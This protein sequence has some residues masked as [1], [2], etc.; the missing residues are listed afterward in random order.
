MSTIQQLPPIGRP[1]DCRALRRVHIGDVSATY[2]VDGMISIRPSHSSPT[3]L[4]RTG[5]I[6]RYFPPGQFQ[7]D[8]CRWSTRR[9]PGTALLT[10]TGVGLVVS[11]F[12]LGSPDFDS[13][14]DIL[15]RLG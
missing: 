8:E 4:P 3:F 6:G 15:R 10:D 5:P 12:H 9:T 1:G 7:A 14:L 11:K 2:V 13:M